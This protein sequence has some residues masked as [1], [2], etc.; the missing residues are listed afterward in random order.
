MEHSFVTTQHGFVSGIDLTDPRQP[1]VL[2]TPHL[3][4]AKRYTKKQALNTINTYHLSGFVFNP[5]SEEHVRDMYEVRQRSI[6]TDYSNNTVHVSGDYY[7]RKARM[8]SETDIKYLE[9]DCK[10]QRSKLY[11]LETALEQAKALNQEMIDELQAKNEKL[12]Q[13]TIEHY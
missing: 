5:W 2:Y 1:Q 7:V 8:I 13:N 10:L 12:N 9:N 3:R 6:G 11:P 4:Y